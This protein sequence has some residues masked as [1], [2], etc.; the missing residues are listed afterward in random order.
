MGFLDH[1]LGDVGNPAESQMGKLAPL[2]LSALGGGEGQS[3]QA[4]GLSGLVDRFHQAGLGQ[5]AQSWISNQQPNQPVT[6]DQVHSALGAEQITALAEKMGLPTT[7]MA[8]LLAGLL[9]KLVDSLTPNGQLPHAPDTG[10]IE[11]PGG[12]ET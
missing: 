2:L 3:A 12:V 11:R 5:I 4:S 9:P 6:P 7:G 1:L 8:G 10:R